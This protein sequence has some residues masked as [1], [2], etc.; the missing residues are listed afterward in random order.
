MNNLFKTIAVA[1]MLA[2]G[3]TAQA[4]TMIQKN[5]IKLQS[6]RMTPEALWA[7]GRIGG[8]AASPDGKRIV[9]QV[10]YYSV[11]ENKSHHMLYV[12]DAD[13]QNQKKL[14]TSAKNETDAVWLNNDRIA[15]LTGGEIWKLKMLPDSSE[16]VCTFDSWTAVNDS[17]R[18]LSEQ[19]PCDK[20]TDSLRTVVRDSVYYVCADV[21]KWPHIM[22]GSGGKRWKI[23]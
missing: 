17:L 10:G 8:Y 11:K 16:Y 7:M 5:N 15:F 18:F 9:Y 3:T 23:A 14:T 19:R 6:D 21:K 12:M 2:M 1:A 13:G 20:A 22:R 4:Q